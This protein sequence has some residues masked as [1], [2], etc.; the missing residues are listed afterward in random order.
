MSFC[1]SI[2]ALLEKNKIKLDYPINIVMGYKNSNFIDIELYAL[3]EKIDE[4]L[5]IEKIDENI[6]KKRINEILEKKR[7]D[8]ILKIKEIVSNDFNIVYEKEKNEIISESVDHINIFR[9]KNNSLEDI[10]DS[11]KLIGITED[12]KFKIYICPLPENNKITIDGISY[13]N[14]EIQYPDFN[15]FKYQNLYTY[16]D[17]NTFINAIYIEFIVRNARYNY[18]LSDIITIEED[19]FN[20]ESEFE[21]ET[22]TMLLL[23]EKRKK[24]DEILIQYYGLNSYEI[25]KLDLT[26]HKNI[27]YSPKEDVSIQLNCS[28]PSYNSNIDLRLPDKDYLDL[29][30]KLKNEYEKNKNN[31]FP[32][33]KRINKEFVKEANN[34]INKFPKSFEKKKDDLIKALFIFD[35]IQAYNKS[36]D[37]LN[38]PT[39][40]EYE[41]KK[42]EINNKYSKKQEEA[43]KEIEKFEAY[44]KEAANFEEKIRIEK[45]NTHQ[46]AIDTLEKNIIGF[47]R[48]EKK[49]LCEIEKKLKNKLEHHTKMDP[50][51]YDDSIFNEIASIINEKPKQCTKIH[52][53]IHKF[54]EKQITN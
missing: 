9:G 21:Y 31:F 46:K 25:M 3:D 50:S 17:E 39:K 37:E 45:Q 1:D 28:E 49:E 36:I 19:I 23:E 16:K 20:N 44:K 42:I 35:Y 54:L 30:K 11:Y 10:L 34:I 32:L 6:K 8:E 29:A 22:R 33:E 47:E 41:T 40:E 27:D 24:M 53:F 18:I 4:I 5:K 15:Q 48:S 12:K 38:I 51:K 7:I 52:N 2:N 13:N 43:R 14:D 26:I